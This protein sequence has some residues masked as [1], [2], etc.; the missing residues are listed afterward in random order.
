MFENN[1]GVGDMQQELPKGIDSGV[2]SEA[3]LNKSTNSEISE[4][5]SLSTGKVAPQSVET[6]R[7]WLTGRRVLIAA[8]ILALAIG[9]VILF[10]LNSSSGGNRANNIDSYPVSSLGL[11][12]A[13]T[14]LSMP[15]GTSAL[16]VNGDV[17]IAGV[18]SLSDQAIANLGATLTNKVS[19]QDTFPGTPQAGN[20]HISGVFGAGNFVGS[21]AGLTNINATNVTSG[22]LAN[23]RLSPEVSLLGQTIE[24]S[25]IQSNIISS[26]NGIVNDGGNIDIVAGSNITVT[27]AGNTIT[28]SSLASGGGISEIVAGTGLIGGGTSSIVN[29]GI[30]SSIVTM[31]GNVFNGAGQ[32]VQLNGLG[33][34][35]A[36]NASQ[37]TNLN[38]S[39]I[40]GGTLNDAR[41]SANVALKNGQNIF[42]PTVDS[43]GIFRVQNAAATIDTLRVDSTN[44]R[45]GIG[46]STGISPNYTLDVNGDINIATGSA[47]RIG[48]VA[49]CTVGGC[50]AAAGSS[51]YI[52][53]SA[54]LQSSANFFI[55]S[56]NVA[57]ITARIRGT[58]GQTANLFQLEDELGSAVFS[59]GPTGNTTVWGTSQFR[60][61]ATTAALR[62][63]NPAATV[64]VLRVD[65]QNG[66][67]GIG[68]GVAVP[69]NYLLDVNGDMN[70]ASGYAYRIGGTQICTATGCLVAG[71]SG[72]YIQNGT[73]MQT[74][75][76]AIQSVDATSI[77]AQIRG[78]SGQTADLMRVESSVGTPLLALS[79]QGRLSIQPVSNGA[80]LTVLRDDGVSVGLQVDTNSNQTIIG[81]NGT[82]GT[83]AL[84]VEASGTQTGLVIDSIGTGNLLSLSTTST[85]ILISSTGQAAFKNGVN[86][87]TAFRIQDASSNN[88]L[89]VD[90][91]N[92]RVNLG[93]GTLAAQLGVTTSGTKVGQI[94]NNTG[95]G[96]SLEIKQSSAD[97]FV[98]NSAGEVLIQPSTN[99]STAVEVKNAS[100]ANVLQLA[101][102]NSA[103]NSTPSMVFNGSLVGELAAWTTRGTTGASRAGGATATVN[104]YIYHL[105]GQTGGG[106]DSN[107]VNYSPLYADGSVAGGWTSTSALPTASQNTGAAVYNGY[108]YVANYSR[109]NIYYA[110]PA[111]NGSIASW[112]TSSV[113]LP[114][115]DIHPSGNMI[116]V[117]G[118]LYIATGGGTSHNQIYRAK[119]NADGS[120]GAFTVAATLPG[121]VTRHYSQMVVANGYLV[122]MGGADAA[123][124]PQNSVYTFQINSDGT[125]GAGVTTTSLPASRSQGT[126]FVLNGYI[127]F[128]GGNASSGMYYAR[129]NSDGTISSWTTAVTSLS[130]SFSRVP[131]TVMNGYVY[132]VSGDRNAVTSSTVTTMTAPR[133][134]LGGTLDLIGIS[135]GTLANGSGESGGSVY[136]AN[137][138]AAGQLTVAGNTT[139]AGG[140]MVRNLLQVQGDAS[141]RAVSAAS[142]QTLQVQDSGGNVLF[143]VDAANRA[144]SIGTA[145]ATATLTVSS[146][147]ANNLFRVVDASGGTTTV[148]NIADGG[149]ATFRN[150]VNSSVAFLIQNSSGINQLVLDTANNALR[151][152]NAGSSFDIKLGGTGQVRNAITRDFACTGSEQ[153]NDI[154]AF[155]A[156]NT[157]TRTTVADSN[158]VAGVVT[159]KPSGTTCTTAIAGVVAVWFSSNAAPVTVGDPVVTST[160]A[161]AAQ[162]T[163][164]PASGAM[165]GNSLS[166]KDGSNLVWVRLR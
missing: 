42:V 37:L 12:K 126:A 1:L 60:P 122:V 115:N 64:D 28:I 46:F 136:A 47:F 88:L 145:T 157:V 53:N 10:L 7:R 112:I 14:A 41:L 54:S 66:R 87:T 133:V 154:V 155:S 151:L 48:G 26:I 32:L 3:S 40:S 31:Q 118:Y 51:D 79:A 128:A 13:P 142:T 161:G 101:T 141:F 149:A 49:I 163:T 110:R 164:S 148:L 102:G 104:G 143:N 21:G 105:G 24:A 57:D 59:V 72:D 96:N 76:F 20:V 132:F 33:Q 43:T 137:I 67:V 84:R 18:L 11:E 106:A 9:G 75:N 129:L 16:T 116:A 95:T 159:G 4:F 82:S 100:G 166:S 92:N 156:V 86:S 124:V 36:I 94:I 6:H 30:D 62:V 63:Q 158:R 138:S 103:T 91:A 127:Y 139:L 144:V 35:P 99:S 83:G 98:I 23:A 56:A 81:D 114:N 71:G 5:V 8:L 55:S 162:A 39:A 117:N 160:L 85:S 120:L 15:S 58:V 52:Q 70:I 34:L 74:A 152:G 135:N 121:S 93:G 165:L 38:A 80:A 50:A 22:T 119:I 131:A 89:Q 45:V 25:E 2:A 130:E 77:V 29:I 150:Q 125:L 109:N 140:A 44:N 108:I 27:T 73:T 61:S 78:A 19:I 68:Y 134:Q 153:I 146:S 69:P 107:T 65:S 147:A 90:T 17:S 111:A 113:A 123:L 97:V